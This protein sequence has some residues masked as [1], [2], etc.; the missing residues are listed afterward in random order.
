MLSYVRQGRNN[1]M[2]IPV[3]GI[4]GRV[5]GET[6]LDDSLFNV[7]VR[8]HL[9]HAAVAAYMANR[10]RGQGRAKTR[11][12][13]RGGGAKPWR[14]KGT[15]RARAGTINSPL[16]RHGGTAHGPKARDYSSRIPRKMLRGALA[17]ALSSK[18]R[19]G[20]IM[21]AED[22]KFEKPNTKKAAG[23]IR[24]L[25]IEGNM[26]LLIEGADGN[27]VKSF[28]NIEGVRIRSPKSM[29]VYDVVA[30]EV[31]IFFKDSAAVLEERLSHGKSA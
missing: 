26:L 7:P 21:A 11:S 25:N 22:L 31:L 2:N 23:F 4:D 27:F 24:N 28:R 29:N 5:A 1:A 16:W 15:G 8:Q 6:E 19:E 10:R 17:S 12:D 18:A 14:Q 3:Y 30:S 20:R 13:V 9:I